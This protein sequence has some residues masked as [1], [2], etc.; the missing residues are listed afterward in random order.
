MIQRANQIVMYVLRHVFLIIF[1][2]GGG[3]SQKSF[4]K[5]GGGCLC[6]RFEVL[7]SP[8][9]SLIHISDR[10][11]TISHVFVCA[12]SCSVALS[13]TVSM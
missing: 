1:W 3:L 13:R 10:H 12:C 6:L 11:Y 7:I 2:V 5:I 4:I 9:S 8:L